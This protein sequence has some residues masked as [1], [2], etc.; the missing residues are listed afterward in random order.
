MREEKE[1]R[2]DA[3]SFEAQ[4]W[5]RGFGQLRIAAFGRPNDIIVFSNYIL[6]FY[7]NSYEIPIGLLRLLV[8]VTYKCIVIAG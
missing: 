6:S 4:P 1:E 5:V 2:R 3:G 7:C 8:V